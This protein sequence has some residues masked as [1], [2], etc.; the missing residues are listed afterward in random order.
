MDV[1]VRALVLSSYVYFKLS[2]FLIL[3]DSD[4]DGWSWN[5]NDLEGPKLKGGWTSDSSLYHVL[6]N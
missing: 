2:Y 3:W 5:P 1:I 4:S 6:L